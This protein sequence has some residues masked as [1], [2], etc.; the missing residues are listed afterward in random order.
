MKGKVQFELGEILPN[1]RSVFARQGIPARA[2]VSER[3]DALYGRA[4]ALFSECAR[5]VGV[6]SELGK[7]EFRAVFAGEGENAADAVLGR[8]F[9]E[10]DHL[11]LYALTMGS[12]VSDR[13]DELFARN[14]FA[15][16]LMLDSVASLAADRASEAMAEHY[17]ALLLANGLAAPGHQ[18]LSYS[19]GYCGWHVSGQKMLFEFL[20]PGRIGISLNSSHMMSPLKSVSGLVVSGP[21]PVHLFSPGFSYCPACK[22]HTCVARMQ[23]LRAAGALGGAGS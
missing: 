11:A 7:R 19:P 16:G 8:I 21:P 17:G 4:E 14:D 15:L 22:D 9:P 10:A 1:R 5:P 12:R 18:V 13:T 6:V 3:I 2:D 23:S 20:G